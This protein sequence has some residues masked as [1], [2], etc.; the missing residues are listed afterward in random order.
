MKLRS[1]SLNDELE[2]LLQ[3]VTGLVRA[4]QC[5]KII[6]LNKYSTVKPLSHRDS[7]KY[8]GNVFRHLFPDCQICCIHTAS[9][10]PESVRAFTHS[11]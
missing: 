6:S 8:T 10:F 7:G 5:T 11:P 4:V 1:I 2:L 9:D 3:S